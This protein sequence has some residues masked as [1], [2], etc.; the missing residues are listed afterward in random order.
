MEGEAEAL[1]AAGS[2]HVL[3]DDLDQARE[4]AVKAQLM[5]SEAWGAFGF[6]QVQ[7]RGPVREKRERERET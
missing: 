6:D 3:Q 4:K 1:L 7:G 5:L 2:L